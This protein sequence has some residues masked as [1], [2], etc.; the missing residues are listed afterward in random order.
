MDYFYFRNRE[1]GNHQCSEFAI[2]ENQLSGILCKDRIFTILILNQH[3]C[4]ARKR[5]QTK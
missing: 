3:L 1:I 4:L 5:R 2:L